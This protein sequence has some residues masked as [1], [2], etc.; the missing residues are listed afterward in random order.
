MLLFAITSLFLLPPA[1]AD[2]I[3]VGHKSLRAQAPR[4][5]T[6]TTEIYMERD[7]K[8]QLVSTGIEEVT[9]TADGVL[10]VFTGRSRNGL[11]I[12]SVTISPTTFAPIRHVE[13][14]PEKQA[15]YRF[16]GG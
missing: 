13:A 15:T 14:L 10:V 5:G 12:D 7:G 2:T 16:A 8:R 3:T 9:K 4:L 1:V 6:D 11:S